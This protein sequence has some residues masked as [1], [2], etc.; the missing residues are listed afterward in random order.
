M[1]FRIKEGNFCLFAYNDVRPFLYD[2]V[3]GCGIHT[4]LSIKNIQFVENIVLNEKSLGFAVNYKGRKGFIQRWS[5]T[6]VFVKFKTHT[7]QVRACDLK[8]Y[9]PKW[10]VEIK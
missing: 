10:T 6:H 4:L 7:K 9:K 3:N 8:W 5:R 2:W 1:T